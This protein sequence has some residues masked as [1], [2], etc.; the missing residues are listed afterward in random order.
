MEGDNPS[1]VA[2]KLDT[3]VDKLDA[4]NADTAGYGGFILGLTINVPC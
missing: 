3:T 4:V 1:V 2:R